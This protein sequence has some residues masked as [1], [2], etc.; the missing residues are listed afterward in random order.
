MGQLCFDCGR[1]RH[2]A[3]P[4]PCGIF[5]DAAAFSVSRSGNR[6]LYIGYVEDWLGAQELKSREL[7]LLLGFEIEITCGSACAQ[8]SHSCL[9]EA[10]LGLC[11]TLSA[12]SPLCD[13]GYAAL[14]ALEIGEHQ[15]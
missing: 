9:D 10:E 13:L 1:D 15:F 11:F 5:R 2:S 3:G 14:Q 8:A 12:T 4:A 6:L 7:F